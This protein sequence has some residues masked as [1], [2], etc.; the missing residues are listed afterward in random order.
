MR[1]CCGVGR[2]NDEHRG[3]GRRRRCGES[4]R[5]FGKSLATRARRHRRN[6]VRGEDGRLGGGPGAAS[7]MLVRRPR[8]RIA[9]PYRVYGAQ[10]A[11]L[12]RRFVDE[13]VTLHVGRNQ[14]KTLALSSPG[15]STVDV[16]VKEF[17]VPARPRGVVYTFLRQSKALRSL[18]NAKKLVG[19]GLGTPDPVACIEYREFGC[20]RQSY[21][22]CRYWPHEFD[23]TSLLYRG[24]VQGLNP[25]ALLEQLARFTLAQHDRGVLHNDYNPGNVLVRPRGTNFDFAI[26]DLNRV[27][28]GQLDM[29][30]RVSGLVRLTTVADYLRIIGREYARLYGTDPDKFCRRLKM[31]QRRF[32]VT[33]RRTKR[34]LSFLSKWSHVPKDRR[35]P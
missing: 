33:R 31:E 17:A 18:T 13:G 32:V 23:L 27:R 10:I 22:I 4:N 35:I 24:V 20:L 30:D 21:Y 15:R 2:G 16:A 12:P 25:I 11:E 29:H 6:C 28:F 8:I 26:V 19:A 34:L 7:P 9:A 3:L 5:R 1:R 14:I